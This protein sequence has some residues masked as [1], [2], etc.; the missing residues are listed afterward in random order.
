MMIRNDVGTLD[1]ASIQICTKSFTL[2]TTD[3]FV[4]TDFSLY[5]NP[6][7]GILMFNFLVSLEMI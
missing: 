6:N 2:N 7:K 3:F 1:A 5:P 4:L